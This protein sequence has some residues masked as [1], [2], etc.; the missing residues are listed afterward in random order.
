[1][2]GNHPGGLVKI[3]T[4]G[5]TLRVFESVGLEGGPVICISDKFPDDAHAAV[6]GTTY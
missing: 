6:L 3:Q 5:Y 2:G 4:V 1:M